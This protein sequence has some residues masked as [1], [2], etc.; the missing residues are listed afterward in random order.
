ME[1]LYLAAREAARKERA[2]YV[3]ALTEAERTAFLISLL[4]ESN[5]PLP[6]P[7]LGEMGV[8]A[9]LAPRACEGLAPDEQS[10]EVKEAAL[11]ATRVQFAGGTHRNNG[12]WRS[13]CGCDATGACST[14]SHGTSY[15]A[16]DYNAGGGRGAF[17]IIVYIRHYGREYFGGK[18][19]DFFVNCPVAYRLW[20]SGRLTGPGSAG[21]GGYFSSGNNQTPGRHTGALGVAAYMPGTNTIAWWGRWYFDESGNGWGA[22]WLH[23]GKDYDIWFED[24]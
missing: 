24:A 22:E 5:D 10:L 8:A 2:D 3:A 15:V 17:D 7:N 9:I 14:S 19:W 23:C 13:R 12:N 4:A 11:L 6:S 1:N 18:S 20:N 16:V 21:R